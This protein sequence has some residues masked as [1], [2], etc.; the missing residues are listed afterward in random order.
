MIAASSLANRSNIAFTP[1]MREISATN[2]LKTIVSR[3]FLVL[4]DLLVSPVCLSCDN[5]VNTQGV[6]CSK[7]WAQ[8]RFIEKPYCALT[9]A[10]FSYDLGVGALSAQAIANPPAF[11]TARSVMLYDDVARLLVQGLKFADRTD[12]A[13]WMAQWMV[14]AADGMLSDDALIV[15]VPL[16]RWRLFGR[17]FNQSAE[18]ARYIAKE[19]ELNYLAETLVRVRATKQQVG[20]DRKARDKNVRGAF[21]VPLERVIDVKG[22]NIVLIDDVFTTGA[23]LEACARALRRSGANRI[24]CLTFAR[25]ANGVALDGL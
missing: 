22:R 23:T 12:L 15:P 8:V 13:P 5:E 25:V 19:Q 3:G 17:R 20:L 7:C 14:R 18:L 21:R 10:P 1:M 9:G 11:D 6:I 24:D 16:H 4:R 2:N